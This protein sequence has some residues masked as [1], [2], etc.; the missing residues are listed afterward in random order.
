MTLTATLVR[1]A[2]VYLCATTSPAGVAARSSRAAAAVNARLPSPEAEAGGDLPSPLAPEEDDSDATFVPPHFDK[3]AQEAAFITSVLRGNPVFQGVADLLVASFE[4]VHVSSGTDIVRQG[5]T[6]VDYFYVVRNGTLAVSVNGAQLPAPYG[7]MNE[8]TAFGERGVIYE[9]PRAATVST[10]TECLLYRLDRR[11]FQHFLRRQSPQETDDLKAV[12][13]DIDAA[14]NRIAGVWTRYD[15]NII[16]TFQTNRAWLWRQWK[17]T[18]L[19][20]GCRIT[21]YNM[22][23]TTAM[24]ILIR[25]RADCTWPIATAPDKAHHIIS[26]MALFGKG[27]GY[28]TALTTFILT[29]FLNQTFALWQ[30]ITNAAR[31]IQGRLQDIMLL[32]AASASRTDDGRYTPAAERVLDD[33][34]HYVRLFHVFMWASFSSSLRVLLTR[35]GMAQMLSHG[36]LRPAD[37]RALR[38]ADAQAAGAHHACLGWIVARSLRGLREAGGGLEGGEAFERAL[39]DRACDLRGTYDGIGSTLAGRIPL[40]Y[41][42]FVQVLVDT[43]LVTAPV[44]LYAE[45]GLWSAFSVGVLT[46]FYSGLLDLAKIFLDPLDNSQL[47]ND[48][49]NC[50]IGVLIRQVNAGSK[51]WKQGAA[52]LPF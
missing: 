17:G 6:D 27:W 24:S 32:I 7:E 42:H 12:S 19:Q 13:R 14:I 40:A 51:R 45:T 39:L 16:R 5:D 26:R 2:L 35:R 4:P 47:F 43:F 33:V 9:E 46:L 29:F 18:V 28:M 36:L 44:A 15:G 10:T 34:G 50:D 48:S 20:H 41:V 52:M 49:V 8:G 37:F 30:D 3:T 1:C 31:K 38:G 23:V 11:T 21:L 25:R 22:A